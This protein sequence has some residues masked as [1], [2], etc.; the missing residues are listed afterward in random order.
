[1]QYIKYSIATDGWGIQVQSVF[2][3]SFG[4]MAI[5][6]QHTSSSSATALL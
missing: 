5:R 1:M 4:I 6:K 2:R 3:F